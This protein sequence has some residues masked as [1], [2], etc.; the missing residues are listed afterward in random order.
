[1]EDL[2]EIKIGWMHIADAAKVAGMT[3]AN[4]YH[5]IRTRP[6]IRTRYVKARREIRVDDLLAAIRERMEAGQ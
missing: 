4:V 6:E 3:R 1:M 5:W 2:S